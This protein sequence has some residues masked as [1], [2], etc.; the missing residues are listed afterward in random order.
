MKL[1]KYLVLPLAVALF[2]FGSGYAAIG[3]LSNILPFLAPYMFQC[4]LAN[5]VIGLGTLVLITRTETGARLFYDG[6]REEE[7]GRGAI[8]III[9]T[10]WVAPL[11]FLL[12]GLLWWILG[13]FI[14]WLE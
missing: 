3:G 5:V 10:L 13:F 8:G 1:L 2:W 12:V 7:E 6:P 11:V 4:A 9:G 14:R